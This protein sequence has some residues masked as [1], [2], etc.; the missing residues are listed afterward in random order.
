MLWKKL[1]IESRDIFNKYYSSYQGISDMTFTNLYIW[2]FGREIEYCEEDEFLFVKV[3]YKDSDPFLFL[4][5]GEGNLKKAVEKIIDKE[6][7]NMDILFKSVT[8]ESAEKLKELF[9]DKF[10]YIEER[11]RFDYL[12]S[13]KELI[14]LSGK[15]FHKKKNQVNNFMK[16]YNWEYVGYSGKEIEELLKLQYRWCEVNRCSE[17]IWLSNEEAGIIK[18]IE[19]F[20]KLN[21]KA[22]AIKVEEEIVAFSFGEQVSSDTVVIHIEKG[23]SRFEGVYQMMNNLFLKEA[24]SDMIYVNREE[25]LGIEGLR[26]A[27]MSY[28][29]IK[30]IKK[31]RVEM[32]E[33]S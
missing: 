6:S 14:E 28:N 18:S 26:Q 13:V 9:P 4:P 11:D 10:E 12:Y 7:K 20:E 2:S 24:F 27:K 16:K 21:F 33:K 1:T 8:E 23:D 25:D 15:R 5:I 3:K 22:G 31:I 17:D 30:L 19:N 32:K 29:P